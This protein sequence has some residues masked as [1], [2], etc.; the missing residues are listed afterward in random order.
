MNSARVS[1]KAD[2]KC[3]SHQNDRCV[4]VTNS[5]CQGEE[6]RR[7]P[8]QRKDLAQAELIPA[9]VGSWQL[10]SL[11]IRGRG[12]GSD[13]VSCFQETILNVREELMLAS[14][15]LMGQNLNLVDTMFTSSGD[16]HGSSPDLLPPVLP[17]APSTRGHSTPRPPRR[18]RNGEVGVLGSCPRWGQRGSPPKKTEKMAKWLNSGLDKRP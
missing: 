18:Q 7:N 9:K 13:P 1:Q 11:A 15:L 17:H 2:E 4:H 5:Q 12:L 3:H 14:G 8:C 6:G 10:G 16:R